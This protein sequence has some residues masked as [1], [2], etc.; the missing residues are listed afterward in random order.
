MSSD[1]Q[2]ASVRLMSSPV[3]FGWAVLIATLLL[4][5]KYFPGL[6]NE[7][8]YAGNVFQVLNPGAFAGDPYRG[9]ESGVFQR[10]LQLSLMYVLVAIVGDLWLDDRFLFL[11]YCGLVAVS[12]VGIDRTARLLGV[13]GIV[14]RLIV[15]MVFLKDHALL[16]NKVLIAHHPDVN[17]MAFAIPLII[18]LFYVVLAGK[19]L[20]VV[21]LFSTLLC[22]VS[23]R[24]GFFPVVMGLIVFA[25][26]GG[27]RNRVI[28]GALFTIGVIV[29]Y[30]GLFHAFPI[31]EG[32]KLAL[33]EYIGAQEEGDANPFIS[34]AEPAIFALHVLAWMGVLAAALFLSPK[35]D[36]AFRGVRIIMALG[37]LVWFL[38][39]LYLTYAPDA[40]KQPL[41]IG[42]APTRSLAWPQNLAYVALFALAFRWTRENL[43]SERI[44]FL[45]VSGLSVLFV[46]GP[47]NMEKWSVLFLAA[48]LASVI[49]HIY[50][51]RLAGH[52]G[53]PGQPFPRIV[54]AVFITYW[55]TIFAGTLALTLA[56][57]F[58]VSLWGKLPYWAFTLRTGVFGGT[59]AAEWV[60]VAGYV[61]DET[62]PGSSVLPFIASKNEGRIRLRAT[63]S[64]GTRA[65]KAM[66][67]PEPYGS[68]F[69]DPKSWEMMFE[70]L[71]RLKKIEALLED[72]NFRTAESLMGGLKPVP[73]YVILPMA[74]LG[75][76]GNFTPPYVLKKKIGDYAIFH[77][78]H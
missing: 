5:L 62:A 28:V 63:R 44:I 29:A 11:I 16:A 76:K 7:Q 31:D 19:S 74:A 51:P 46:I 9:P 10:P 39:G 58:S 50:L 8:A 77:R 15:L 40:L 42:F 33:W 60:N 6:E 18:W 66:P 41:L 52:E 45:I 26:N 12:L 43:P 2:T 4:S 78:G 21:L 3:A 70:Q 27:A 57:T 49:A 64:L 1:L 59:P 24:N 36:P 56:V 54:A 14:E 30:W 17:I 23:L 20:W 65:G 13:T 25:A 55:R 38:G 22:M 35:D 73:D 72:R 71:E 48:G 68:R 61:R 47:G 53:F 34:N 67:V 32:T 37:L 69:R 75:P